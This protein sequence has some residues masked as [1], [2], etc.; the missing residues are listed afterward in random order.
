MKQ[1]RVSI[2]EVRNKFVGIYAENE[3]EAE[4]IAAK[5]YNDEEIV[6]SENDYDYTEIKVVNIIE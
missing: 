3:Q 2:K 1:Y 4:N 5:R 6:L